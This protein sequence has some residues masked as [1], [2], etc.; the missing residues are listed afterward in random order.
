[1]ANAD[2][3]PRSASRFFSFRW[4]YLLLAAIL[5]FFLI[6][7]LFF[8]ND[9]SYDN[10]LQSTN[11]LIYAVT[12]DSEFSEMRLHGVFGMMLP[13]YSWADSFTERFFSPSNIGSA[14]AVFCLLIL[15]AMYVIPEAGDT[16]NLP[17]TRG[18][19]LRCKIAGALMVGLGLTALAAGLL[20]LFE[21]HDELIDT[22]DQYGMITI[23]NF[24][25]PW[26]YI[27]QVYMPGYGIA[28][29]VSWG[30]TFAA[31]FIFGLFAWLIMTFVPLGRDRYWQAERWTLIFTLFGF[32]LTLLGLY[33]IL[34]QDNWY[35]G[36]ASMEVFLGGY[37]TTWVIG[38]F[39]LTWAWS[40]RTAMF[41][42][43][44]RYEKAAIE[45]DEPTCF[46]CG[47]DLRM[48]AS[49]KCPECGVP[50]NPKLLAKIHAA[51]QAKAKQDT[52][53][54]EQA[55]AVVTELME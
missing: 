16:K 20:D 14:V 18:I 50:V 37:Y 5:W 51:A 34:F 38:L 28:K 22:F 49:D 23:S 12:G 15:I 10:W 48:L 54:A 11:L 27:D 17:A 55:K 19:H 8:P 39:I 9:G 29:P 4:A 1:M 44:R 45:T 33:G 41:M 32:V 26:S 25:S 35:N 46:A 6:S 42:M 52:E 30:T 7:L 2:S 53:S 21:L 40:C 24:N 47:Y 36:H 43:S 13:D 31:V 3:G